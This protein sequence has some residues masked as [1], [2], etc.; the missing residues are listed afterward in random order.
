MTWRDVLRALRPGSLALAGALA[1]LL[2]GCAAAPAPL[3]QPLP[4]RADVPFG[5][6]IAWKVEREGLE[7]SY[8]LGTMHV[9]DP[10]IVR[11]SPPLE[12]AFKSASQAAFEVLMDERRSTQRQERYLAAALLPEGE[13]L[14]DLLDPASYAQLLR[15]ARL[16]EP[17]R[18][19]FGPYHISRFKPWFVMEVVGKADPTTRHLDPLGT[20]L[21]DWLEKRARIQHKR[22][23]GLETFEEQLAVMSEMSMEDQISLLKTHLNHYDEGYDYRTAADIYLSGDTARFYGIWLE[24][25]E[26]LEPGVARRFSERYLDGRNR[27]MVERAL[28]LLEAASTFIAVGALH[29][30]GEQG[31]LRLLEQEGFTLT[32]LQ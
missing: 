8:L 5:Q 31:V 23:V 11:L 6:G 4:P 21:D 27:L 26:R 7:P 18:V 32:R 1:V 16:E 15:I 29:L 12:A 13:A 10:A 2:A 17:R 22:V 3:P 24:T 25:L 28:P 20:I 30:P 9:S 19:T 14:S